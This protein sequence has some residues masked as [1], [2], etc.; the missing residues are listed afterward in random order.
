MDAI[1]YKRRKTEYG[2]GF[3]NTKEEM[4]RYVTLH[5]QQI[6]ISCYELGNR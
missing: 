6:S 3:N 5:W 4:P 2:D 1:M